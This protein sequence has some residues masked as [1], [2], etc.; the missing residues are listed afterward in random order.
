M[1][2]PLQKQLLTVVMKITLACLYKKYITHLSGKFSTQQKRFG[3]QNE[4]AQKCE[5]R[6]IKTFL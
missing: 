2:Y 6:V 1:Y 4:S 5:K 3:F